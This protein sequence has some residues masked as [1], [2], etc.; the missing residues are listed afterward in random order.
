LLI[1]TSIQSIIGI[2]NIPNIPS[3]PNIICITS[4]PCTPN[5]TNITDIICIIDIPRIA[6]I[7]CI[8]MNLQVKEFPDALAAELR[9]LAWKKGIRI[10]ELVIEICSQY[11]RQ[12]NYNSLATCGSASIPNS[13]TSSTATEKSP[14]AMSPAT[15]VST[16]TVEAFEPDGDTTENEFC[17]CFEPKLGKLKRGQTP[18]CQRCL[19][20]LPPPAEEV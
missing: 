14:V 9:I 13:T 1:I 19:K 5:I 3:I 10:R 6:C 16:L 7:I 2:P 20:P 4:I 12:P 18:V 17:L 11:F 8:A 15:P